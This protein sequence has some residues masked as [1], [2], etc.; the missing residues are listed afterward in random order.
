MT[1]LLLINYYLSFFFSGLAVSVL[2]P[3]ATCVDLL[4]LRGL[5]SWRRGYLLPWL[6][7]YGFINII[8]FANALSGIFHYGFKW[9]FLILM[10]CVFCLYSS[11]RHIRR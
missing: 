2:A 5:Q 9:T 11:W 3:L 10:M 4:A 8:L 6:T 1:V 7:L